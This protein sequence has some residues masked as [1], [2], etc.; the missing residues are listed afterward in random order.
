[1]SRWNPTVV[2]IWFIVLSIPA[3]DFIAKHW[4]K[5]GNTISD[6]WGRAI[7]E[8]PPWLLFMGLGFM[9]LCWHLWE[10]GKQ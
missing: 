1:M 7:H 2:F 9:G 3:W 10:S 4:L 6:V 5:P 8:W